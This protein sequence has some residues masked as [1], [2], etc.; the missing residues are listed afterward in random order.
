[1]QPGRRT[2]NLYNNDQLPFS[3]EDAVFLISIERL[4]MYLYFANIIYTHAGGM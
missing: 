4:H 2:K 3:F 1:M